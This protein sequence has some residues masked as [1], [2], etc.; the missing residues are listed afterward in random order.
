MGQDGRVSSLQCPATLLLAACPEDAGVRDLARR[1]EGRRVASVWSG[2]QPEAQ[3]TA[4][5]L[6]ARL[7]CAV[8]TPRSELD[9]SGTD[10][11]PDA[12]AERMRDVLQEAADLHRGEVVLLLTAG[13]LIAATVPR[14]A[15]TPPHPPSVPTGGLV[16]LEVDEEWWCRAWDGPDAS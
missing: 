14:L 16:E 13:G 11:P 7:G 3:R 2:T 1:L 5:V 15:R 8:S 9:A 4:E 6:A 12:A 10:E